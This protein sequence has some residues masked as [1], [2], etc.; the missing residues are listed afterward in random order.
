MFKPT[1][2]PMALLVAALFAGCDDGIGPNSSNP[3]GAEFSRSA[4]ERGDRG[5]NEPFTVLTRNVYIGADIAPI[6]AAN[7][8]VAISEASAGVW[9]AVQSTDFEDRAAALA[10]EIAEHRP[11][12]V[13]LQEVARF[14]TLNAAFQPTGVLDFLEILISEMEARGLTYQVIETQENT[15]AT[16]PIAY[17]PEPFKFT[18]WVDF[19]DR[20]VVLAR[21]DVSIIDTDKGNYM[22]DLEVIP[23]QVVLKR[24]WIRVDTEYR[25]KTFHFVNTH[26]EGQSLAPV[27]ALQLDELVGSVL[28]GLPG[29]TVLVGDLNSDAEGGPGVLSWTPTYEELIDNG[30][31]DTWEQ[32][33]PRSRDHGYT[34][35]HDPDLMNL[36]SSLDQ[37]IDFV[38]IR[39]SEESVVPRLMVSVRAE[40]LGDETEDLTDGG[41]WP[42]DH[43]GV[44]TTLRLDRGRHGEDR[45][46][47]RD[48]DDEDGESGRDPEDWRRGWDDDDGWRRH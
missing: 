39:T 34:C 37:R 48:D 6:F 33:N 12:L 41:L 22:A 19:I 36:R 30:F 25:G 32:A 14:I 26:L 17:E 24:G 29:V 9:A 44:L 42:S 11:R 3:G 38:L 8:L 10:E 21:S 2:F 13:G 47:D 23:G 5:A 27:Q 1:R 45:G 43:G 7:G 28:A 16:L 15:H 46:R 20:D 18:E 31:V 4:F 40:V 35:C